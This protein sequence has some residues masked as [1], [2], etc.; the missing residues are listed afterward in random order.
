MPAQRRNAWFS[1]RALVFNAWASAI[2]SGVWSSRSR[3]S[4]RAARNN[5]PSSVAPAAAAEVP[6]SALAS[7]T[8][9]ADAGTGMGVAATRR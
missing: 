7:A 2:S 8:G 9:D 5:T 4:L 1:R 6:S 3:S